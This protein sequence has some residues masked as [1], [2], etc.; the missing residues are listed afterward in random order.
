[1]SLV[2]AAKRALTDSGQIRLGLARL[3]RTEI[4][5]IPFPLRNPADSALLA[6]PANHVSNT[7]YPEACVNRNRGRI[8]WMKTIENS[9]AAKESA[10]CP[11]RPASRNRTCNCSAEDFLQ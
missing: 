10:R 5:K 8:S 6:R 11:R 3:W 7:P 1:M 2:T 9:H 4:G